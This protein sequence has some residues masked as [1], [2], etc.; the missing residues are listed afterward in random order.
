MRFRHVCMRVQGLPVNEIG[1]GS[2]R[3]GQLRFL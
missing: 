3:S 1:G 2:P